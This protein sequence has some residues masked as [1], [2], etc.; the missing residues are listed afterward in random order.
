[1]L[2]GR[3]SRDWLK[4]K[5]TGRQEFVIAGYTRGSGARAATFGALVLAV[6]DGGELR[7]AG[8]VGTGFDDRE[9]RRLLQLLPRS[10]GRTRRSPRRRGWR[11]SAAEM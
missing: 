10:S 1:M 7:Y 5:A 8:N 11:A 3:R 4:V 6:N 9:I 2:E